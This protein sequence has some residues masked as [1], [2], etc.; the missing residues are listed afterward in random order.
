[1]TENPQTVTDKQFDVGH[2]VM[3]VH[4]KTMKQLILTYHSGLCAFI[5]S[6]MNRIYE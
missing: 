5:L 3:L 4:C 1:M 6:G 2:D